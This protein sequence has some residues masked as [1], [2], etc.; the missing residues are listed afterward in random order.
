MAGP[1]PPSA[2]VARSA[3]AYILAGGRGTRLHELTDKRAKPAVF[4]GCNSRIVDF[5]ISNAL[6]SGIRKIAVATQYKAHSLI[7]HLQRGWN[8]LR[9]ERNESFDILPA[10][11]RVSEK[12]VVCRNRR[13]GL[14]EHRHHQEPSPAIYRHPGRRSYLQDGL[15]ADAPAACSL[16][17]R[18]DGRLHRGAAP[19]GHRLRR[20]GGRRERPRHLLPRKARGPSRHARRSRQ[21]ARQHGHLRVRDA[22]PLRSIAARRVPIK[23]RAGI[24]ARTSSPTWCG[25]ETCSR[26]ASPAHACAA[27]PRRRPIGAMSER[28]MPIGKPI[29]T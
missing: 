4:F 5:A 23:G 17:S 12:H 15:R 19:R 1:H 2:P 26:I 8:F 27:A 29:S 28:S 6:N 7:R 11:Q 25:R 20:D 22:L 3:M 13:C 14:S 9:P 21:G 16:R 10:S 18:C 24:S